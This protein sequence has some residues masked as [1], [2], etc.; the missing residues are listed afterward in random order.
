MKEKASTV[1]EAY[2][3]DRSVNPH[4]RRKILKE[5]SRCHRLPLRINP[6]KRWIRSSRMHLR[7]RVP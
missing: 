7:K 6:Q 3:W 4:I 2:Q 1:K 5:F